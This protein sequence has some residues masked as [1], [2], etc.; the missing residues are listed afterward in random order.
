[1]V[2]SRLSNGEYLVFT[3]LISLLIFF[4]NRINHEILGE[5]PVIPE[6]VRWEDN[7]TAEFDYRS[8]YASVIDQ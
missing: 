2:F 6:G 8:I 1:M 3:K 7:L 4:G 5:N